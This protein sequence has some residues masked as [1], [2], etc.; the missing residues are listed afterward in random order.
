MGIFSPSCQCLQICS[1]KTMTPLSLF[2]ANI[3]LS[4]WKNLIMPFHIQ[5][6]VSLMFQHSSRN[7]IIIYII[8]TPCVSYLD[9]HVVG[10]VKESSVHFLLDVWAAADAADHQRNDKHFPQIDTSHLLNTLIH[11]GLWKYDFMI[12]S[13]TS[14]YRS[15]VGF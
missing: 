5:H 11:T 7:L 10:P 1:T 13:V 9:G 4:V 14:R 15:N 12:F 3:R 8:L 6:L 2:F